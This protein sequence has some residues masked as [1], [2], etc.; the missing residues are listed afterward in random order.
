MRSRHSRRPPRGPSRVR[1]P[2]PARRLG[3][4]TLA[5]PTLR[6]LTLRV[7]I[8]AVLTI[9]AFNVSTQPGLANAAAGTGPIRT[10]PSRPVLNRPDPNRPAPNRLAPGRMLAGDGAQ[11]P[12]WPRPQVARL[13]SGPA[14]RWLSGHRGVDLAAAPGVPVRAPTS[15]RVTYSGTVVGRQV[16]TIED[17]LGRRH[18]FEPVE[19]PLPAGTRV[20]QGDQVAVVGP[21]TGHC[22]SSC[23]HWGV[24]VGERY[25]DP[26]A[27]IPRPAP[28]LLPL[29][30]LRA[31][32]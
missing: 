28:V 12:L 16:I 15:G 2:G 32:G 25:V 10:D 27:L 22:P 9:G 8:L 3:V 24:R 31:G 14:Q 23:L 19:Q 11:W 4:L 6:V 7:L 30:L 1:C 5:V 21:P 20:N 13:F 29:G 26:L 18:S 17:P